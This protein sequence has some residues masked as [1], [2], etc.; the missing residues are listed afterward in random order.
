MISER[1]ALTVPGNWVQKNRGEMKWGEGQARPLEEKEKGKEEVI[2][3][4]VNNARMSRFCFF[5]ICCL[6]LHLIS[7]ALSV[8]GWDSLRSK[9][10]PSPLSGTPWYCFESQHPSQVYLSRWIWT[11]SRRDFCLQNWTWYLGLLWEKH[12]FYLHFDDKLCHTVI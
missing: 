6:S 8:P 12:S 2:G 10:S 4:R 5:D 3:L 11:R 1:E 9:I 7:Q